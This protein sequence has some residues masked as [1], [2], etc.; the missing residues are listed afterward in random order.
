MNSTRLNRL[1]AYH[2][3]DPN[4]AFTLYAIAT[5]YRDYD[6]DEALKYYQRL[7]TEHPDY[8][9]TYY[10]AAILLSDMDERQQAEKILVKGIELAEQQGN[11]LALREL[12]NAHNNFLFEE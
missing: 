2:K 5:E 4:D 9:A 3:E 11:Q 8:L 1:L 7:L 10:H 6:D 12:K